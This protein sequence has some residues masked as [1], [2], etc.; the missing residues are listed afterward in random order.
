MVLGR[1]LMLTIQQLSQEVGIGVD[2]LRVWERRYHFPCP[3]RDRR[4]HRLYDCEQVEQLR[5]VKSLQ[6]SGLRPKNIFAL[7]IAERNERFVSQH[8]DRSDEVQLALRH[9]TYSSPEQLRDYVDTCYNDCFSANQMH[10]DRFIERVVLPMVQALNDGAS[11]GSVTIA[12]EHILSD[13]LGAALQNYLHC[14]SQSQGQQPQCLF[15]TVNGERHKLGLL[16][17]ACLFKQAGA[18]CHWIQEDLPLTELPAIVEELRC[19]IVAL[20]FS[21]YYSQRRALVDIAT[22]RRILPDDVKIVA[23]GAAVNNAPTMSKLFIR[24]SFDTIATTLAQLSTQIR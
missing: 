10:I 16:M 21:A 3:E 20:S 14:A 4:G 11:S 23:G 22:L 13:I 24:T 19:R 2:T 6:Q 17:A 7:S 9:A 8:R 12:R 18:Q 1:V 15:V 5:I